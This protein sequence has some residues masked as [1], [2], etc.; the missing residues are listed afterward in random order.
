ME[1]PFEAPREDGLD[2]AADRV[3]DRFGSGALRR[4]A[5]IGREPHPSVPLLPD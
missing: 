3:R 5:M 4:A 1:L 2:A